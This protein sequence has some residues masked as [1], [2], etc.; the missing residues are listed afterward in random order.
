MS[1]YTCFF[2]T[3]VAETESLTAMMLPPKDTVAISC[4]FSYCFIM[5][6]ICHSLTISYL[7]YFFSRVC[8]GSG[9]G[10]REKGGVE[11]NDLMTLNFVTLYPC[12]P[13]TYFSYVLSMYL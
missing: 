10:S 7:G 12:F 9:A 6:C 3:N 11:S 4:F 8:C 2:M 5:T 13:F 1:E